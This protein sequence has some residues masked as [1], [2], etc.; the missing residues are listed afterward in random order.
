[1]PDYVLDARG[2]DG[3]PLLHLL[4]G[5]CSQRACS[6]AASSLQAQPQASKVTDLRN[7]LAGIL[8]AAIH[9]KQCSP[10]DPDGP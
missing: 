3:S 4:T 5:G 1:M 8:N 6:S 9:L 10:F 7:P 2:L